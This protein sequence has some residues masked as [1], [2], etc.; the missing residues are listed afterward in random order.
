MQQN[1]YTYTFS[2]HSVFTRLFTGAGLIASLAAC[3]GGNPAATNP[4]AVA[5]AASVMTA[6][7]ATKID[8]VSTENP[9]TSSADSATWIDCGHE[10]DT[11][12]FTGTQQVRYGAS[13]AFFY[14]TFTSSVLCGNGAF[15]DPA[16]G[17]GKTCS[18]GGAAPTPTTPTTPT[19]REL[20]RARIEVGGIRP[21]R[22]EA[23]LR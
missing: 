15:G 17:I 2:P 5:T 16:P 19:A 22:G 11:C 8:A 10:N 23:S 18:V 4:D 13:G 7:A 20:P 9:T 1:T 14:K 12:N 6:A 21:C 3:G